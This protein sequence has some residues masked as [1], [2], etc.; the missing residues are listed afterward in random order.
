MIDA[1]ERSK[2]PN[3]DRAQ[4]TLFAALGVD[5]IRNNNPI[6]KK[7][8]PK[9]IGVSIPMM[10]KKQNTLPITLDRIRPIVILQMLSF[11]IYLLNIDIAD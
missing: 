5:G 3:R 7:I 10:P 2:T 8:S 6:T 11:Y 9:G 1:S 4:R